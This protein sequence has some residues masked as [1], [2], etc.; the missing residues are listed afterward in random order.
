MIMQYLPFLDDIRE[1]SFRSL[2]E[3]SPAQLEAAD[4]L[5]DAMLVERPA[6]DAGKIIG[7]G[8][9]AGADGGKGSL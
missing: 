7:G 3:V 4:A 9:A 6:G 1:W 5:I 2:P 8:G